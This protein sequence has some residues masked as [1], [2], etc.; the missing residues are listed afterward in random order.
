MKWH[1]GAGFSLQAEASP[2]PNPTGSFLF[3]RR[4]STPPGFCGNGSH[5][6]PLPKGSFAKIQHSKTFLP[7]EPSS[8]VTT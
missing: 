5:A 7:H 2:A 3:L 4:P 6:P 8:Q 1:D